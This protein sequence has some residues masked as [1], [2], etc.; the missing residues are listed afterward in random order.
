MA[1][2]DPQHG[3]HLRTLRS[4][5]ANVFV[6]DRVIVKRYKAHYHQLNA[7]HDRPGELRWYQQPP[8]QSMPWYH[9]HELDAHGRELRLILERC[10][11]PIGAATGEL[12]ADLIDGLPAYL[13]Q[14]LDQLRASG[15]EHRD[16]HPA[17]I[18]RDARGFA[19]IDW[20]WARPVGHP[21]PYVR[22]TMPD[23]QAVQRLIDTHDAVI[24]G[25]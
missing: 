25:R 13:H 18:L 14:L 11:Q 3:G 21:A 5:E 1:A 2:S 19:V 23:E 12:Y 6:Y 24:G 16:L 9:A 4:R 8:C 22:G 7:E 10:G 17:N 15:V 20:T